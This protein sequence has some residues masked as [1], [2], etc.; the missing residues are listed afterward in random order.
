[1]LELYLNK[2]IK[3][4]QYLSNANNLDE[5][6]TGAKY[7]QQLIDKYESEISKIKQKILSIY[8]RKHYY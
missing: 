1:M 5:R 7:K 2:L 4:V 3:L 8:D 6:L